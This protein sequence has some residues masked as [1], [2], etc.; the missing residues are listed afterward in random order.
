MCDEILPVSAY[1]FEFVA[2][3]NG[4]IVHITNREYAG[5]FFFEHFY[6]ATKFITEKVDN[7]S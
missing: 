5:K 2:I 4:W 7:E 6:D 1:K 3:S